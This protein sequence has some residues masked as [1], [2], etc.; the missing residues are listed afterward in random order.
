MLSQLVAVLSRADFQSLTN[1]GRGERAAASE[2]S[3][4]IGEHMNELDDRK[5]ARMCPSAGRKYRVSTERVTGGNIFTRQ[6]TRWMSVVHLFL[7]GFSA[8]SASWCIGDQ[9]VRRALSFRSK[10]ET[11]TLDFIFGR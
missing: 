9:S 4:P 2:S 7:S 11:R 5:I 10:E 1:H 3:G 8:S 6:P